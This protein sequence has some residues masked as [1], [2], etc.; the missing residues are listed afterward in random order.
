MTRR[1]TIEV[2]RVLDT[3]NHALAAQDVSLTADFRWGIIAMIEAALN[4][5]GNYKGYRYLASE[6]APEGSPTVLREGYDAT[7]RAY[8]S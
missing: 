8:F 4:D 1:K 7:R 2:A 5:S 3:A 6:Y